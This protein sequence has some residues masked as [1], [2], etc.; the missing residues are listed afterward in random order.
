M[1]IEVVASLLFDSWIH[2]SPDSRDDTG[3]RTRHLI[4]EGQGVFL[5]L[6]VHRPSGN[7]S[8]RVSGQI[9][10]GLRERESFGKVSNL[11]VSLENENG[12]LALRTNTLGEFT[13]NGIPDGVWNLTIGF[14]ERPFIVQG[15]HLR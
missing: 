9:V 4:Y 11:L 7:T 8:S 2:L 5:D 3:S 15:I 13:F 6:L 10:R 12:R 14:Q 1:P